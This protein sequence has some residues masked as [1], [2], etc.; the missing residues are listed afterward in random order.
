[1]LITGVAFP[2]WATASDAPSFGA[3][4]AGLIDYL[5]RAQ[6]ANPQLQAF[7]QRYRAAMQRIPTK[8]V[9]RSSVSGYEFRR[10]RTN[11]NRSAG[12][13][14]HAQPEDSLVW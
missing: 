2:G 8:F 12:E 5:E 3:D 6:S 9:T 4:E 11:P 10:V 7:D 13:Y 1:M 14:L